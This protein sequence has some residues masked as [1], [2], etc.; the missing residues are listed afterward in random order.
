MSYGSSPDQIFSTML[1]M[2]KGLLDH[3]ASMY[4]TDRG[5]RIPDSA[6]E[7]YNGLARKLEPITT[8]ELEVVF[9][10]KDFSLLETKPLYLPYADDDQKVIPIIQGIEFDFAR[11][12]DNIKIKLALCDYSKPEEYG[13]RCVCFRL[14]GPHPSNSKHNYYHLQVT[15]VEGA[16]KEFVRDT[17]TEDLQEPIDWIPE[18]APRIPLMAE[19]PVTLLI[20]LLLSLY[21]SKRIVKYVDL[22][23]LDGKWPGLFNDIMS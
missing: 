21:G 4:N 11:E 19:C 1:G 22:N 14:E 13:C 3:S 23:R 17:Q 15:A 12:T 8:K 6:K 10:D 16:L 18:H 20:A 9:K 7:S 2:F 5:E